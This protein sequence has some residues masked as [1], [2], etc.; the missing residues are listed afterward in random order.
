MLET[1]SAGELLRIMPTGYNNNPPH[2]PMN[3]FPF[4]PLEHNTNSSYSLF[5]LGFCSASSVIHC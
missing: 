3:K 1:S 4:S 2:I 5:Q